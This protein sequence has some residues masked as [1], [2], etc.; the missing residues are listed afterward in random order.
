MTEAFNTLLRSGSLPGAVVFAVALIIGP[1]MA[2][3]NW[4]FTRWG[5][6]V[7]EVQEHPGTAPLKAARAFCYAA[8]RNLIVPLVA[9]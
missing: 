6:T 2:R 5:M 4:E 9:I 3:A 8:T 7:N 1:A